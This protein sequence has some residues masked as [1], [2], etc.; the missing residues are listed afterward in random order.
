MRYTLGRTWTINP[1]CRKTSIL[2]LERLTEDLIVHLAD[3]AGVR[4]D[5]E[6]NGERIRLY[7]TM[8][9]PEYPTVSIH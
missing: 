2:R 4:G 8:P 5:H 3:V 9:V 6:W 7:D 1:R